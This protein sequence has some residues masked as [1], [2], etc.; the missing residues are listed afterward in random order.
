MSARQN[1]KHKHSRSF[2]PAGSHQLSRILSKPTPREDCKCRGRLQFW[3]RAQ[4]EHAVSGILQPPALLGAGHP[5]CNLCQVPDYIPAQV[6]SEDCAGT[7]L[8]PLLREGLLGVWPLQNAVH[9]SYRVPRFFSDHADGVQGQERPCRDPTWWRCH[10]RFQ[11]GPGLSIQWRTQLAI[12]VACRSGYRTQLR[13]RLRTRCG[14]DRVPP[15]FFH[16]G[17]WD[18]AQKSVEGWCLTPGANANR[19]SIPGYTMGHA[20]WFKPSSRAAWVH[21]NGGSGLGSSIIAASRRAQVYLCNWWFDCSRYYIRL[22]CLPIDS[23]RREGVS[24]CVLGRPPARR[25]PIRGSEAAWHAGG[26]VR[27]ADLQGGAEPLNVHNTSSI[28]Y[29]TMTIDA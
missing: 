18:V 12:L 19:T 4:D 16:K 14:S 8:F 15:S 13:R 29:T 26:E 27:V 10:Q 22:A 23:P 7:P 28:H 17:G 11:R 24:F 1:K 9:S 2:P 21:P 3:P 25:V 6:F 20:Q 5:S